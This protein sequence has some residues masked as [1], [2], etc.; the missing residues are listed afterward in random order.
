MKIAP[1]VVKMKRRIIDRMVWLDYKLYEFFAY[2]GE[3]IVNRR[4][5]FL[6]VIL[7]IASISHP[8]F[9][10]FL[11]LSLLCYARKKHRRK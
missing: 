10:G 5:K 7:I 1:C 2:W 4:S 8:L 3:V 9:A 6:Y 11:A